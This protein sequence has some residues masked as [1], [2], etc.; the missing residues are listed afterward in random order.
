ME[1][2][3]NEM[4]EIIRI[5]RVIVWSWK[6]INCSINGEY[7]FWNPDDSQEGISKKKK[8]LLMD[9]KPNALICHFRNLKEVKV[10]YKYDQM[11]D[12]YGFIQ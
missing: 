6:K 4:I 3:E 2:R 8:N 5:I 9:F 1:I 12:N 7:A 10:H 11:E